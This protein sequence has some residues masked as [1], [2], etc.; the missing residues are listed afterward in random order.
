M[1]RHTS[2]SIGPEELN[3]SQVKDKNH[4]SF[5]RELAPKEKETCLSISSQGMCVQENWWFLVMKTYPQPR[6]AEA[7]RGRVVQ[8]SLKYSHWALHSVTI[9]MLWQTLT[10]SYSGTKSSRYI[11]ESCLSSAPLWRRTAW[12]AWSAG[13]SLD[14]MCVCLSLSQK[15]LS[16]HIC[17]ADS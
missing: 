15:V 13:F 16:H 9:P 12:V 1:C 7:W 2:Q 3:P 11:Y 10:A 5:E 8:R 17:L 14:Q 4:E 6:T